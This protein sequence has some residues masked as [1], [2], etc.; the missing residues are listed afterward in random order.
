[1]RGVL[2]LKSN[3]ALSVLGDNKYDITIVLRA[4]NLWRD[5]RIFRRFR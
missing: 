4:S 3:C 2:R 1:M 5:V